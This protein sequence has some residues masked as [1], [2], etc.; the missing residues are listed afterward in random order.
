MPKKLIT[1]LLILC[2]LVGLGLLYRQPDY[3]ELS[4]NLVFQ[5]IDGTR[6]TLKEI[7]GKPVLVTFWS[8]SCVICMQEVDEL[9]QLY[10]QLQ[11]GEKFDLLALS[12][13]YDR[14]DTVIQS[15]TKSNMLYPVYLDLQNS[16]SKAFGDVVV[17][18]TSFLLNSSGE[19]IYRHVGRIDF[20]LIN[21]KLKELIG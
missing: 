4:D 11:G 8:P 9:N 19:I 13:H 14:P 10:T 2:L 12:M 7:K 18:P 21:F 17:T 15:S 20:S 5:R 6:Q 1:F 3:P 16:L